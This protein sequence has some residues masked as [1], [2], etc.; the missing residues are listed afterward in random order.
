MCYM[1]L[2]SLKIYQNLVP[3]LILFSHFGM[4]INCRRPALPT[5]KD[6][7]NT[8]VRC[9]QTGPKPASD[10][11]IHQPT[12]LCRTNES[13]PLP[14]WLINLHL[15]RVTASSISPIPL[16]ALLHACCCLSLPHIVA[17]QLSCPVPHLCDEPSSG[18]HALV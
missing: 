13:P 16:A 7:K 10:E 8:G 4:V 5:L 3:D 15:I 9:G 6:A 12:Q 2:P 18:I 1:N 11:D 17:C 14:F